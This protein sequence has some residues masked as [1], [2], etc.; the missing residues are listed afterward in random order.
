[1]RKKATVVSSSPALGEH[2]LQ[3]KITNTMYKK[4]VLFR[5][6]TSLWDWTQA[7]KALTSAEQSRVRL[8]F[9]W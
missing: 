2:S 3:D 7:A 6:L 1:M 9:S 8:G 5:P 4:L